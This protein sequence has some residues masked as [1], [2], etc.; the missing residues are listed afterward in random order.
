[1]ALPTRTARTGSS[2][3]PSRC[4]RSVTTSMTSGITACAPIHSRPAQA[5]SGSPSARALLRAAVWRFRPMRVLARPSRAGLQRLTADPSR[6][7][8]ALDRVAGEMRP[9]LGVAHELVDRRIDRAAGAGM[10]LHIEL[11]HFLDGVA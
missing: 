5:R 9:D 11:G 8:H 6:R 7:L 4:F 1:M 10:N 2:T 3:A